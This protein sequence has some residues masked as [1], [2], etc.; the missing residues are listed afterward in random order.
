MS[1]TRMTVQEAEIAEIQIAA[2]EISAAKYNYNLLL[3]ARATRITR[4]HFPTAAQILFTVV[5]GDNEEEVTAREIR[6][7][8]GAVLWSG[9]TSATPEI[10]G[11]KG[12]V[13]WDIIAIY[14]ASGGSPFDTVAPGEE[15]EWYADDHDGNLYVFAL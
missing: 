8:T 5:Q 9:E 6:D 15:P 11:H 1:H 10:L 2:K 12:D 3:A 4:E 13:L 14:N 7:N